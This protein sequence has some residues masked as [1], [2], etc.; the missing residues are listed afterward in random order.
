MKDYNKEKSH[1]MRTTVEHF[2]DI[3]FDFS[4]YR[5]KIKKHHDKKFDKLKKI[6]A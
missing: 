5:K 1:L 3:K 6:L 4:I 2:D